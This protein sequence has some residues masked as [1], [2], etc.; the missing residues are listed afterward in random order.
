MRLSAAVLN[1]LPSGVTRPA[2]EP[3]KVGA[4][5]VHLGIGAFHRAHQAVY[6]DDLIGQGAGDWRIIGVSLRSPTVRDQLLAQDG[7]YTLVERDGSEERLRII[8]SVST[9]LVANEQPKAV[10]DAIAAA[11]THIVSLTITEKGYCHDPAT[12]QINW[13]HPDIQHDLENFA[14]PK[15]AIGYLCAGLQ[16]R[17]QSDNGAISIMSCDNLPHNGAV[18]RNVLTAFASRA[19]PELSGWIDANVAFP[20]TMVD[21]IVP[22]TTDSDLD[23]LEEHLGFRDEGM[24][25]AEPFSQWVIEDN[26][27][28]ARPPFENVGAQL[29]DDVRPFELAK[30]R[31]LNGCHS[32]IAYLGLHFGYETVDQAIADPRI[33]AVVDALMVEAAATLP[34]VPGLNT[35]SYAAALKTRFANAALQHRLAQI[36]MDGSQKLPQRLLGAIADLH[37]KGIEPRAAATGVAA[38]LRHFDGPHVNDPLAAELKAAASEDTAT[39]VDNAM[40]IAAVFGDLGEAK[41][42]R[43]LLIEVMPA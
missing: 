25:K 21:R 42:L 37:A 13:D 36:A 31:M 4:A 28:G 38:W 20:S 7:L 5:I 11:A 17:A 32:T 1:R 34:D 26:F 43:E 8:G 12:G 19:A 27:V 16:Q 9:V 10:I 40:Q 33:A 23:R 24:V 35:T 30:L 3:D 22:A 41:W 14:A 15:S 2:Y 29:V 18:L 6:V 39:L